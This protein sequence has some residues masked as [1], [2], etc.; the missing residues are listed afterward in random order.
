MA[1]QPSFVEKNLPIRAV[2]RIA[3]E[4]H[5]AQIAKRMAKFTGAITEKTL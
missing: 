3:S 4:K 2:T 5:H 1:C